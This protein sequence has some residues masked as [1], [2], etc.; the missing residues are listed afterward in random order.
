MDTDTAR[1]L[2][3][4]ERDRLTAT[5]ASLEADLEAQKDS[6][7]ELSMVD[8]HQGDVATETFE[9]EKDLSIIESVRASLEDIDSAEHRLDQGTYGMCEVC[10]EPIGDERL[11]AVPAAR[12][13]VAHQAEVE[14]TPAS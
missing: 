14:R 9:R 2:L 8:E 3:H 6:L 13:C 5:L 7:Q 11:E 4:D 10:H 1:R 12:F